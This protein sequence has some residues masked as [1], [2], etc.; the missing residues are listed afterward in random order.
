MEQPGI[1]SSKGGVERKC[2]WCGQRLREMTAAAAPE[3]SDEHQAAAPVTVPQDPAANASI[4]KSCAARITTYR[5]PVL[6]VSREWARLYEDIGALLRS[7]PEIQVILDRRQAEG[8]GNW[9]GPERRSSSEP[10]ELK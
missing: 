10:I 4:C 2:A 6:V 5:H 3:R 9:M 7:R 1:E 8:K